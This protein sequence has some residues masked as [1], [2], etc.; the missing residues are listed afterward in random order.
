MRNFF[1]IA[2]LLLTLIFNGCAQHH[3]QDH[4]GNWEG[5][6]PNLNSFNFSLEVTPLTANNYQIQISNTE[7]VIDTIATSESE[8]IIQFEIQAFASNWIIQNVSIFTVT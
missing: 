8:D 7:A 5:V 6:L 3:L 1:F 4:Q 2:L